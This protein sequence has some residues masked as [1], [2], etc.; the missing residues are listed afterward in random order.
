METFCIGLNISLNVSSIRGGK[1]LYYSLSIWARR[2]SDREIKFALSSAACDV[3]GPRRALFSHD[4]TSV[5]GAFVDVIEKKN[6]IFLECVVISIPYRIGVATIVS[7]L[8]NELYNTEKV[9]SIVLKYQPINI[10][11]SI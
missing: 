2:A 5:H 6:H 7:K 9:G 11:C 1:V 8:V 3:I 10:S 4:N